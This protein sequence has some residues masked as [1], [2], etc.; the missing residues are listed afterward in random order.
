MPMKYLAVLLSLLIAVLSAKPCAD[1]E[2]VRGSRA[3]I[4]QHHDGHAH[5]SD[6]CSPFCACA[7]CGAQ[8][9]HY[10]RQPLFRM[11]AVTV[12]TERPA[13]VYEDRFVSGYFGSIWQPPQIS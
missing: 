1:G 10:T 13:S 5:D 12:P 4:T 2:A 3:I 8:A 11:V 9:A 6:L 7:C